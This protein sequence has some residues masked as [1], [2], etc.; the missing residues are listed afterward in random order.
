MQLLS[1]IAMIR[2][3]QYFVKKIPRRVILLANTLYDDVMR[4]IGMVLH[5]MRNHAR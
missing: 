4:V 2:T 1:V 5:N 3:M